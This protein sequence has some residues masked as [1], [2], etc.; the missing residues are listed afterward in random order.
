MKLTYSNDRNKFFYYQMAPR[1]TKLS[2]NW[3]N[4][5][6]TFEIPLKFSYVEVWLSQC[7]QREEGILFRGHYEGNAVIRSGLD[8]IPISFS[9]ANGKDSVNGSRFGLFRCSCRLGLIMVLG[10]FSLVAGT[11]TGTGFNSDPLLPLV[12][13]KKLAPKISFGPW[14]MFGGGLKHRNAV[15]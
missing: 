8:L 1:C 14:K 2:G 15:L 10:P 4:E 9:V 6:L 3:E 12:S 5:P 11:A 7:K 13:P